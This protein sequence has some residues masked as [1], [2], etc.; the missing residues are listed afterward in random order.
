MV[1]R[2][3]VLQLGL[4]PIGLQLTQLIHRRA[5]LQVVAAVDVNEGLHGR[6][7]AE[8]AGLPE[9]DVKIDSDLEKVLSTQA[10]DVAVVTTSSSAAAVAEHIAPLLRAG[11]SVVTTCEELSYPWKTQFALATELDDCAKQYSC[12]VLGTG[13]NPGF[14]MDYL[15]VVMT[16]LAQEVSS[17]EVR[18][19]QDASVRRGPFQR[20][21]GAGLSLGEFNNQ[22]NSGSLRHVG[23]PE[24]VY[25]IAA[26][27]R[28]DLDEVSE[29]IEPVIV[30]GGVQGVCQVAVGSVA[31]V[32][33]ITLRFV[34]AV[35]QASPEDRI[36]INGDPGYEVSISP[37]VNGDV[38][39]ASV[40]VNS[41]RSLMLAKPGLRVMSD[42]T[43][44]SV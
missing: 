14:L 28:W 20:K 41:I 4:G 44:V 15:P 9:L 40:V 11:V 1:D 3:R 37:P 25:F 10:I 19:V 29:S 24:S 12:A 16:G 39:T 17:I 36:I 43:P 42:L 26:K 8:L 5:D 23:L 30:E 6:S 35:N 38:A 18:R 32:P 13:V 31:N 2:L 27:L 21:I 7:L 33:K 22:V 34:A